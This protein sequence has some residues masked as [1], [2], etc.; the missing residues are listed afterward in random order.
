MSN[1]MCVQERESDTN[2]ADEHVAAFY[3]GCFQAV[4]KVTCTNTSAPIA[5]IRTAYALT[6][7]LWW[8]ELFVATRL[9]ATFFPH[10][11]PFTSLS[12]IHHINTN[13]IKL[14]SLEAAEFQGVFTVS[15]VRRSGSLFRNLCVRCHMFPFKSGLRISFK[16]C[17][18]RFW[19]YFFFLWCMI[20]QFS[21][22]FI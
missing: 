2:S 16:L 9:S 5:T 4:H 13:G 1:R 20:I 14:V 17:Q 18:M 7:I 10:C 21:V 6:H 22:K 12:F 3:Q 15:T 11:S 8:G 19:I